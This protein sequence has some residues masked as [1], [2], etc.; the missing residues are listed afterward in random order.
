LREFGF[1]SVVILSEVC[2]CLPARHLP[3]RQAGKRQVNSSE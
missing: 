3:D 1:E 2:L